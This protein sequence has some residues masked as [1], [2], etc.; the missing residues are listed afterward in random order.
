MNIALDVGFAF[1]SDNGNKRKT[2]RIY[3]GS[4]GIVVL[5]PLTS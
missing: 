3:P 5:Y 4:K 2:K 1:G